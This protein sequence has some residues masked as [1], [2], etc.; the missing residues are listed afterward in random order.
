MKYLLLF[1]FIFAFNTEAQLLYKNGTFEVNASSV[2][3]GSSIAEAV[4]SVGLKSNYHSSDKNVYRNISFSSPRKGLPVLKSPYVLAEA[5]YNMSLEEVFMNI[6]EDGT[7]R[8]GES[9]S[10]VWTRDISY[11]IVLAL[12]VVYPDVAITS[13]MAKVK[14]NRIIQDTG[15]GGSWPISSD[16]TTWALAA[17]EIYTVTGDKEWL[18]K[19]REIIKNTVEDDFYMV[20]DKE[21]GLMRGESSFL[22]WREQTYPRWMDSKD[23]YESFNLGTN[24]VHY[25]TLEI[26]ADMSELLG[27]ESD[28]YRKSAESIRNAVNSYL[29]VEESG[30]YGQFLYGREYLSLSTKSETLGEALSILYGIADKKRA[31]RIIES[32]P[33]IDFGPTCVFPQIPFIPPYHNDG[34]WPFVSAF[35][36]LAAAEAGNIKATEDG[37][38]SIYRAAALYLTNKEN[39]VASTGNSEGTEINSNRQLWSVAGNLAMV[40]KILFGMRFEK[41]KLDFSPVIP[42]GLKGSYTLEGIKYRNALIDIKVSGMGNI[43]KSF[44]INGQETKDHFIPESAEGKQIVEIELG[45]Y[46]SYG[47]SNVVK[48]QFAPD[49]PVLSY[50]HA[51]IYWSAVSGAGK[52]LVYINGK[53]E[54]ETE[55]LFCEVKPANEYKEYQVMAV[56]DNG[57]ESFLSAPYVYYGFD[58]EIIINTAGEKGLKLERQKPEAYEFTTDIS[59]E[60]T[61][62]L[63]ILYSNG[64]GP[65]N[66][67]NKACLRSLYLNG[68]FAD[69]VIMPQL[70]KDDWN[71]RGYSNSVKV[72]LQR[73][74]NTFAVKFDSFSEN[75][76]SEINDAVIYEIRLRRLK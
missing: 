23:I 60:G 42:E 43:V 13:L 63:D 9:W 36:T 52:Y 26:L 2:R 28:K 1:C 70:G 33:V 22:D 75:M 27:L 58:N 76:N 20:L 67:E 31:E 41:D 45:G 44:K 8:T 47:K 46:N 73:G 5:M 3:E 10:G 14:N 25:K 39:L 68:K 55:K 34:I 15:T 54:A 71:T 17:W 12:A 65:I 30:W 74:K 24:A 64:S 32:M 35:W 38:F 37:L 57:T 21:T 6:E 4:S 53:K 19:A 50:N 48:N 72:N 51:M 56:S 61:Y 62:A 16:R 59:S 49:T 29:W 7:F 40:Y 18:S 11:S 66:T 69:A